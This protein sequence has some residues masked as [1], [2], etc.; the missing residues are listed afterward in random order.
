MAKLPVLILITLI[1]V[2]CKRENLSVGNELNGKW[3]AIWYASLESMGYQKNEGYNPIIF[4]FKDGRYELVLDVNSCSGRYSTLG[5]NIQIS[6]PG[7]TKICC[8][9]DFS[10]K[11]AAMLSKVSSFTIEQNHD[12]YL[13][14]DDWG[15]IILEK[16][17]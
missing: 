8:D 13:H 15:F 9:S 7:C 12:L 4:F 11:F 1:T 3:E 6:H 5:K 2:S 10:K 16:A 17:D 14:V